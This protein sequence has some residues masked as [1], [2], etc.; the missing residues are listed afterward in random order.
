MEIKKTKIYQFI[1]KVYHGKPWLPYI[2]D[3]QEVL[4]RYFLVNHSVIVIQIGA[5]DGVGNDFLYKFKSKIDQ[6]I[7]LEPRTDT[8]KL[9]VKNYAG[10][11]T[12]HPYHAALDQADGYRNLYKIS[13]SN[14]RWATG[15][16]SFKKQVIINHF[17]NGYVQKKAAE[18]GV[19][20]PEDKSNWITVEKVKTT[21]FQSL[22]KEFKLAKIDW[23]L[24]D[25]EGFDHEVIK[26][27]PFEEMRP[28][29]VLFE[30]MHLSE[31]DYKKT[32]NL[33]QDNNYISYRE[34]RDTISLN[35]ENLTWQNK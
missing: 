7:L 4:K 32:L 13:F 34:G 16:S 10:D 6:G 2:T 19:K 29:I 18:E 26:M 31:P 1:S 21:S 8:Y 27:F 9:L 30:H 15:L 25:T 11:R 23:L 28:D 12:F 14:S 35:K 3:I 24:I 17:D 33:L 22:I 20:L 5:N